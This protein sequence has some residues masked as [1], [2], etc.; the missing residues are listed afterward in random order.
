MLVYL[1]ILALDPNYELK[2]AARIAQQFYQQPGLRTEPVVATN[3]FSQYK[4][5]M[6]DHEEG[7]KLL[8]LKLAYAVGL[9]NVA[10]KTK[11]AITE[12]K[13]MLQDDPNDNIVSVLPDDSFLYDLITISSF[14]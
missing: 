8:S 4:N 11:Q 7:Q 3:I 14:R 9:H 6:W 10:N 2:G 12:I 1:H 5:K 13:S